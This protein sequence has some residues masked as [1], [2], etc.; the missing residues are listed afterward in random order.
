MQQ[1]L[2]RRYAQGLDGFDITEAPDP[3]LKGPRNILVRVQA[4]SVNPVDLKNLRG[5][6]KMMAPGPLPL[7]FGV[8]FVGVVERIEDDAPGLAVG[9]RVIGYTGVFE[10]RAFATSIAVARHEVAKADAA[11]PL[12]DLAA[13]PL[14]ALTAWQ[15]LKAAGLTAGQS[16]LVHGAGGGVGSLAVQ[17]A[18]ML[19]AE[20]TATCSAE[21]AAYVRGLGAA[22]VIDFRNG[23][24]VLALR[25]FDVA[26]DVLGSATLDSCFP[27][28]KPGGIAVSTAA[29]PS[30]AQMRA[31]GFE[32]NFII[33][34]VLPLLSLRPR[35]LAG[36]AGARYQALMTHPNEADMAAVAD[37]AAKGMR[38]RVGKT[39]RFR[40]LSSA[41]QDVANRRIKGK[42]VLL[43]D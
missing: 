20:V 11:I 42:A 41:L 27:T 23:A 38:T 7:G 19:R 8:D 25:G 3:D 43:M 32:P 33:R 2:I 13:L 15:G 22:Q 1:A 16:V 12:H 26:F 35:L 21:D 24:T 36:R 17:V 31:C 39:Y 18:Q 34:S 30:T 9:D 29:A 14:V 40:D 5:E 6:S 37:L 10:M 28:L 4:V